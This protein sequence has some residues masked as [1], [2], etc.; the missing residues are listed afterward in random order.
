MQMILLY[1]MGL[2]HFIAIAFFC[3]CATMLTAQTIKGKV[4]DAVT[5][6]PVIGA[7]VTLKDT[8]FSTIVNLDGSYSFKNIPPGKYDLKVKHVGY[9][10]SKEKDIEIKA[11]QVVKN[12]DFLLNVET[13]DLDAAVVKSYGNPESD[14]T[15]RKIE[16]NS[17]VVQNNLSEKAIQ[18][19]PDVTVANAMQRISGVTVERTSSGEGRYAIIRGMDQRYNNTL[20]NGIKIPSPDDKF[21]YV[22]MDIF[23]S[24]LLERL[25]VIKTLTPAM[26]GDAIGGTMNLVMKNAPD[27]FK[28][29]VHA[30][31]GYNT[32]FN[33]RSFMTFDKKAVQQKDPSQINGNAYTATDKDFS[34]SNLDFKQVNNPINA[35]LGIT[36]GNR[37]FNKRLGVVLGVSFQHTYRGSN[38][39]FFHPNAQPTVAPR[40]NYPAFDDIY[41]RHYSTEQKRSG[42]NNKFDYVINS[43]NKISLYNLYINMD[44]YQSRY[45]VDSSLAIQRTGP[46]SGNVAIYNRSR[47]Q[48]QSIY[49]S[50]LQGEHILS[51][52]LTL[53]WNTVYSI[54]DQNVPDQAEYEVDHAVSTDASTGKSTETPSYVNGMD[55]IWR[56]N[57]DKDLAAYV[58]LIITPLIAKRIVEISTGG[59]AR[60]KD[61]ENYYN[62]YKLG[63]KNSG[64]QLFTNIYDAQYGFNNAEAGKGLPINP[65][66]Y[67]SKEDVLAGYVQAKYMLTKKLQVLGGV[68]IENTKQKFETVMPETFNG[69]YGTISYTD[70][71]PSLHFKYAIDKKQNLRLSYYKALSRPGFF[72]VL[73]YKIAGEFY[74]EGGNLY[75]KHTTADNID[76]RYEFFP[77]GADQFLVGGFYKKL[78]NPIEISILRFGVGQQI[79]Q[80]NNFGNAENYG[81]E[82][83]A[84]KFFGKFGVNANYT[85]TKSQITTTKNYYYRDNTTGDLATKSVS[86]SR[87]LQ[88]QASHVGN[89]SLLYKNDK[90]GLDIQAALVYTGERIV[91]VSPYYEL[92]YW[93][94]PYTQFDFSFEKKIGKQFA[95]Y[96]KLN[97][98]LNS[99]NQVVIKQPNFLRSGNNQLPEQQYDDKIVVQKENYNQAYLFG[100]RFKMR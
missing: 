39:N 100:I 97:N 12:I 78:H 94:S 84:T 80:P 47:H 56:N 30:A 17:D 9:E 59:L 77:N 99:I 63:P 48:K 52:L 58:N 57:S 88:G 49:N 86:Q 72:E 87:P 51:K 60:H 27:K 73:P 79:L 50:T 90:I 65:N 34:R 18:L 29:N 62:A 8:K 37:Y 33:D 19:M 81:L 75:L 10:K 71:L 98:L 35:Q 54:A 1:K 53:K 21:R 31:G 85:F 82:A 43:H 69:R 22:P 7:T 11:G 14:N 64:Q 83:V 25:E 13:K 32:L 66:T 23:P 46:G 93:Q 4:L 16:K 42:I 40:D 20:V 44:E 24:D 38:T 91:Q 67:T 26:E 96:G 41:I 45:T 28:L 92:D 36:A 70:I 55:R 2:R 89:L 3:M 68:R 5:G 15:N 61:R 76:F 6:E 74:Q 95:F